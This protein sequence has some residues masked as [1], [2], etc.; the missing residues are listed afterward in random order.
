MATQP[1]QGVQQPYI[2]E[3]ASILSQIKELVQ[4][5]RRSRVLLPMDVL[6]QIDELL[7]RY[8]GPHTKGAY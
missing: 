2:P 8:S 5:A 1:V 6:A 3:E 7:E 4:R